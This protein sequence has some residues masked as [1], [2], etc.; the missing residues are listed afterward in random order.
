MVNFKADQSIELDLDRFV[1]TFERIESIILFV[2]F[3]TKRLIFE[4]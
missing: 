1:L 3:S 4:I 2:C